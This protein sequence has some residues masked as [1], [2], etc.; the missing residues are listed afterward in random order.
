[1]PDV[2][3]APAQVQAKLPR[4][5]P[6]SGCERQAAAQARV[7]VGSEAQAQG[8]L[9]VRGWVQGL[10][11]EEVAMQRIKLWEPLG[12]RCRPLTGWLR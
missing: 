8:T 7:L 11:E 12:Q 5:A 6:A 9:L 2:E 1:M 4:L 3:L 10:H